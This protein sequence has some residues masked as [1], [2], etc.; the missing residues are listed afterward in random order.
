MHA[1]VSFSVSSHFSCSILICW[2]RWDLRHSMSS[3]RQW[4]NTAW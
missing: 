2:K 1:Q 4:K 3:P